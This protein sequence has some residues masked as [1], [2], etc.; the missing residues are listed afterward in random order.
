MLDISEPAIHD[1]LS[2]DPIKLYDF[3]HDQEEVPTLAIVPL[4]A[5]LCRQSIVRVKTHLGGVQVEI[6]IQDALLERYQFLSISQVPEGE[7]LP[8]CA[9][10]EIARGCRLEL[11]V[12]IIVVELHTAIVA[13]TFRLFHVVRFLLGPQMLW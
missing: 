8:L 2:S 10:P 13:L 9:S 7:H 6:E 11:L 3:L 5:F 1:G 4:K 12:D